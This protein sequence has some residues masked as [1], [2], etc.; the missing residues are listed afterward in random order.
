M[1]MDLNIQSLINISR[2]RLCNQADITTQKLWLLVIK[3]IAKYDA[4]IAWA[5]VPEGIHTCGC[6]E[7]FSNCNKCTNI[8]PI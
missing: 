4:N 6:T 5:C 3:E 8:Q 7:G 1:R 2:K